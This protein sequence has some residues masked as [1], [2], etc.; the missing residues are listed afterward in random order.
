MIELNR[1]IKKT[2]LIIVIG[3][4]LSLL[5]ISCGKS[6]EKQN[7]LFIAMDDQND[8][9]QCFGGHPQVKTPNIDKLAARGVRFTNAH[10]AVP[11]C[12]PSRAALFTGRQPWNTGIYTNDKESLR[13][14][15]RQFKTLPQALIEN[16]Y[17]TFGAGKV[18]HGPINQYPEGLFTEHGPRY[19]QFQPLT[20]EE[21]NYTDDEFNSTVDKVTLTHTVDRG[22][23]QLQAVFPLNKMP[24]ERRLGSKKI[25]SFDWGPLPVGDSEMADYQTADWAIERLN[26]KHDKPFFLAAGFYRPHIPLYIP[27]KYYDMYPPDKIQLPE[28]LENDLADMS[29]VA[30]DFAL[31]AYSAGSHKNVL[32]HNQWREAVAC[33]LACVTFVDAQ[34]GRIIEA[35]D[36]SPYR[37][38]TTIVLWG[39]NGWHLG[40]KEHWG[41]FAGWEESTRIPLVIVPPGSRSNDFANDKECRQPVSLIDLYPTMIAINNLTIPDNLDGKSLVPF[42]QNPDRKYRDHVISTFGRGNHSV[43]SEQWR[44]TRY[45]DGSEELYNSKEDPNEFNNLAGLEQFENKKLELQKKLPAHDNIDHFISM[46]NWK[47]VIHKIR[48][49]SE[50]YNFKDNQ[51]VPEEKNVYADNPEIIDKMLT[52]IASNKITGKYLSIPE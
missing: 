10:C 35:L 22:P 47:A 4:I 12:G 16:G 13:A 43:R 42:L 34:V 19:N 49:E 14:V 44:Y 1:N 37:D 25:E 30:R 52:Y 7:I 38:N 33:Y 2:V 18:F 3:L 46:G 21:A 8:W 26:R 51:A 24:R 27:Q 50:L 36:N 40:E 48:E 41:K 29:E 20:F 45:Y 28:I 9:I 6:P 11:I 23:G 5:F 15:G 39:D 32:D 17:N 31:K